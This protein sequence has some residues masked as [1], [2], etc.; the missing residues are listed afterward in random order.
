MVTAETVS[1]TVS[2]PGWLD[3]L[4]PLL[5]VIV[6]GVAAWWL[7]RRRGSLLR[8]QGPLQLVQVLPVGPRERL[9]L[10]RVGEQHW[11]CG[12]T[13]AQISLIARVDD[14]ADA[15]ARAQA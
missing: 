7:V 10:V 13:P 3:L 6:T 11:L 5:I 14:V 2:Q 1:Q 9:L 12:A 8:T 4:L 15:D